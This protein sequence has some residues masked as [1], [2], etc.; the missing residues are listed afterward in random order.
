MTLFP[1]EEQKKAVERMVSTACGFY[2]DEL[3]KRMTKR[4]NESSGAAIAVLSDIIRKDHKL[5]EKSPELDGRGP[6]YGDY[7]V[8]AHP[9]ERRRLHLDQA[10][11]PSQRHFVTP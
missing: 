11:R 7:V 8:D 4:S 9:L 1:A 3:N 5:W 6:D 2:R 10:Q